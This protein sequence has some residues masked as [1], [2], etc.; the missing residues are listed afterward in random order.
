MFLRNVVVAV[1]VDLDADV[2]LVELI[3]VPVRKLCARS[4]L[5]HRGSFLPVVVRV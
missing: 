4:V 5:F 3:G 1:L 2:V